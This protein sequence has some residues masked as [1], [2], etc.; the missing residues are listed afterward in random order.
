MVHGARCTGS[1]TL[2][3]LISRA[4]NKAVAGTSCRCRFLR[5]IAR[6]PPIVHRYPITL[7][8]RA[9][10]SMC[11]RYIC[12]LRKRWALALRACETRNRQLEITRAREETQGAYPAATTTTTM[13]TQLCLSIGRQSTESISGNLFGRRAFRNV[14]T[15][16]RGGRCGINWT[17]TTLV[18]LSL[19]MAI[20][21]IHHED[22]P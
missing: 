6:F 21:K 11:A 14:H 18:A 15:D 3:H 16:E 8:T 12:G 10:S 22:S 13:K 1:N 7:S 17:V 2:V 9:R 5:Y 19:D 20:E 4:L